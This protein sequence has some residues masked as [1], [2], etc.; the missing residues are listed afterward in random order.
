MTPANLYLS[1]LAA[2]TQRVARGDL[3]TAAGYAWPGEADPPWHQLDAPGAAA[4]RAAIVD[5]YPPATACRVL[6]NVRGVLRAC[7]RA[8]LLGTDQ[9]ARL[10]A[11]LPPAKGGRVTKGRALSWPDVGR[12]LAGAGSDEERALLA[13]A[14]GGGLR[15]AELCA[16]TWER[17]TGMYILVLGK[18][19]RE[20]R[21]RLP[22][23]AAQAVHAWAGRNPHH[24]TGYV[25]RWRDGRSVWNVVDRA[26]ERA[27]LGRVAPHDLRRTFA[28]LALSTGIGVADLRR[29]MGHASIATTLKY[30][31]RAD[32]AVLEQAARLDNP[33]DPRHTG[34]ERT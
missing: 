28:S 3:A 20:R 8:N 6:A 24:R 32:A 10:V 9:L 17:V 15:R 7:W 12:L 31:K 11:C 18:G 33:T 26:A 13:L 4:L 30:D 21:L 29:M 34:G 16:L 5:R 2:S 25:F 22:T 14:T 19:N 1:G 23:W 27:G